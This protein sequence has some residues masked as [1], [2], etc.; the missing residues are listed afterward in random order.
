MKTPPLITCSSLKIKFVLA[1]L[2]KAHQAHHLWEIFFALLYPPLIQFSR[3]EKLTEKFS[4]TLNLI[5]TSF[6]RHNAKYNFRFFEW[7]MR[8]LRKVR[9]C[10]VG[11]VCVYIQNIYVDWNGRDNI[12]YFP[13]KFAEQIF[14]KTLLKHSRMYLASPYR[15]DLIGM[16]YKIN[17]L[18]IHCQQN[19]FP[20]YKANRPRNY[21]VISRIFS[22]TTDRL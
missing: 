10:I 19:I 9:Q 16:E 14:R 6:Y 15:R 22:H 12:T 4:K 7:V 1:T 8:P 2:N 13:F 11:C 20:K 3:R 5:V 17:Q 21:A 18:L